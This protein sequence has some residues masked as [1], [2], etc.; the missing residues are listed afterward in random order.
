M[1]A[2]T[3]QASRPSGRVVLLAL[4]VNLVLFALIIGWSFPTLRHYAGG[5][6][7]FDA[8]PF[9]YTYKEA[10]K[11]VEALG[12]AGRDFY[13]NRQLWLD[14][15]YPATYGVSRSLALLW[16][17]MALCRSQDALLVQ[18]RGILVL[19]PL[20]AMFADWGENMAIAG[21][22]REWESLP[23]G[24]VQRASM[25]STAKSVA[26]MLTDALVILMFLAV[27]VRRSASPSSRSS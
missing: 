1:G 11:L 10:Q 16:L 21:M 19:L 7:P 25:L 2:I 22:L 18:Y 27:V 23:D 4:L 5:F 15:V 24:L 9:G 3:K 6:E 20:F 17:A 8:R 12:K 26:V 14:T 13:R